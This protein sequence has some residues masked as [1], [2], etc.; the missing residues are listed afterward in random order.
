MR[1]AAALAVFAVSATVLS[2]CAAVNTTQPGGGRAQLVSDLAGRLDHS[3]SLTYTAV[4]RLPQG[5]T[6]TVVQAQDPGRAAYTYPGGKLSLTPQQTADCRTGAVYT[7][8]TLTSPP[9]P[10]TDPTAALIG[11]IVDRG[12]ISPVMVISLLSAA[13]LDTQALVTTRDTTIAG[14]NA[15]CVKVDG[16]QNAAASQFEVCVT[17][18]GL[19]G[20]FSG[21][22]NGAQIDIVLDRFE[23]TVAP[24]AFDLPPGARIDDRRPK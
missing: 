9:S 15:T 24:D 14:E 17:I 3:G 21:P 11:E 2:G 5:A 12:L 16:M 7:T 22:V 8:C 18:D 1:T 23:P 10:G 4:Y 6:A 19:L 13:A 20:S